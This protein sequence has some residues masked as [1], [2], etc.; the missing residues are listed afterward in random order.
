MIEDRSRNILLSLS[1]SLPLRPLSFTPAPVLT[2]LFA[3]WPLN[4]LTLLPVSLF[5]RVLRATIPGKAD[6]KEEFSITASFI[7]GG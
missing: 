3:L 2:V 7:Y 6:D 1:P 5:T 4:R